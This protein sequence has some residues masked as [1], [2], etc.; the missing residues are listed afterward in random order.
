MFLKITIKTIEIR[1]EP[2]VTIAKKKKKYTESTTFKKND[3]PKNNVAK[4]I[5]KSF[6]KVYL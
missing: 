3:E 4:I 2:D 1:V 6:D 5:A